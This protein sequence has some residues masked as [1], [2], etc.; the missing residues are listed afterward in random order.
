MSFDSIN[1][2]YVLILL[3]VLFLISGKIK[4]YTHYFSEGML[5]QIIVGRDQKK[6][7]FLLLMISFIFL[8]I[9]LA[10]PV[11][12]NKPIKLPTESL[13]I[14]V[15]F[16]ISKSMMADDIYPNRLQFAKNKFINLLENIKD[17]KVG[18]IGFSASSFLV[19]PLTNDITTLKYLVTNLSTQYVSTQGSDMLEALKSTEQLLENTK[20][21]ALIIFTDG[22]DTDDFGSQIT[23]AKE[24]GIKVF[25][26][27]IATQK[28]GVIKEN[29]DVLKDKNGNIVVTKLNSNIK[30]LALQSGGAYLEYSTNSNDI[31]LFLDVIRKQFETKKE[32]EVTIKDNEEYFYIPLFLAIIFYM[33]AISGFRRG[34]K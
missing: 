30:E 29:E 21:R 33:I 22:T 15:A 26:Y 20:K 28:G 34:K 17:E 7:N 16:D 10:K 1:A 5:K 18:V 24:Q 9:A 14:I 11:W 8:I 19:A 27:A 6:L 32:K 2:F 23:Y 31:K 25:V 4:D 12:E 3:A 13:D